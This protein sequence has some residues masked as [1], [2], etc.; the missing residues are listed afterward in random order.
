MNTPYKPAWHK[1]LLKDPAV[2]QLAGFLIAC[3]VRASRLTNRFSVHITPAAAPYMAG[4]KQ[5]VLCCWHGRMIMIPGLRPRTMRIMALTSAHGDGGIIAAILHQFGVGS[6]RGSSSK[7]GSQALRE[8]L[9][10]VK[11]GQSI[12]ITPDG[13]RGPAQKAASGI[14]WLAAKTG[15]PIVPISYSCTNPFIAKSWDSF[16]LPKPFGHIHICAA[17]PILIPPLSET[18]TADDA[19]LQLESA[20]SAVT[21][22]AEKWCAA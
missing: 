4:E 5:G 8:L 22:E 12:F 16:M 1:R 21:A 11:D 14:V 20:L 2:L 17:D 9:S 7:R 19:A 10:A 15:L 18:F 13:P 6:I 3:I